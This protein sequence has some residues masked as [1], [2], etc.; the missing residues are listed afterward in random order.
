VLAPDKQQLQG[1]AMI[2]NVAVAVTAYHRYAKAGRTE[3]TYAGRIWPSAVACV[4]AGVAASVFVDAAVFRVL[5]ALFLLVIAA[6]EFR[7]LAHPGDHSDDDVRELTPARGAGIGAVMGFLSGLLGIG[8]GVVGIPLM[9]AWARL[10]MKRAVVTSVCTMLPLT[11]VGAAMKSVTL[12][13]TPVEGGGSAL[14][15]AVMIAACLLPTAMLGSWLGA[16]L[17]VRITGRAVRWVLA[18]FLPVSAVW[19]AWPI[20]S[21]WIAAAQR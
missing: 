14:V 3:W 10:P 11:V 9:R 15:P 5:F 17:N 8:G 6:R 21:Q 12:A 1:A 20:V 16:S 13:R 19:M 2:S 7:L 18:T 4:L